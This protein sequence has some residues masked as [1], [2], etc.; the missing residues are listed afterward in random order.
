MSNVLL[1]SYDNDSF[2]PLFPQNIFYLL[3]ALKK[4]NHNIGV[5]FQDIHHEPDEKLNQILDQGY[6]NVIGIGAVAGYYPY[7]KLKSLS[8]VINSHK[9]RKKIQYVLGGHGPAGAPEFFLK[10]MGADAVVVGE[11]EQAICD[12]AEKGTKGIIKANN[13]NGDYPSLDCYQSFPMDI[14]R[15][16]RCPTSNRTEFTMP[17]LSSRGCKWSCSFCYRMRSGFHEREIPAIMEEIRFLHKNYAISH[18]DFEDELLMA[19]QKRTEEICQ[20]ILKLPFK[21]KW[22]CNGRLNFG[23]LNLL[24]TMKKSGCE[25]VN[26]GI[27]SL[28][29]KILNQMGKGLTL[30]QIHQGVEVTLKVGLSPGLNLLWGFP[31]DTE[32]NLKDEVAF[33][34]KYDPCDELRTIRPVTPYPGCKLFDE[35]VEKGLVKDTEE[36]YETKHVNSDL[37]S[38]NFMDISDKDAHRMLLE[39]NTELVKNYVNKKTEK[40]L[41][42]AQNLYLKGDT[43]FRGY[44]AV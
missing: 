17:I 20:A 18:F 2:L 13:V 11:G 3:G 33:L 44:R 26:Y 10:K 27:E 7:R 8:K 41:L 43:S 23:T 1:I 19:S 12:I 28:N 42:S 15:L 21:I 14:Y 16:N 37:I 4:R 22:D 34:K 25:Y 40:T 29:Q 36:F 39:A 38:I 32:Q 35:A 6:F 24:E 5:W 9:S 30:N 31:G